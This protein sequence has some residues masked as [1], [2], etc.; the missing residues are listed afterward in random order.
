[1]RR[2]KFLILF[3]LTL[4]FL[5][6][7]AHDTHAVSLTSGVESTTPYFSSRINLRLDLRSILVDDATMIHR[8][9]NSEF[10]GL[11][12]AGFVVK[13]LFNN[14]EEFGKIIEYYYGSETGGKITGFSKESISVIVGVIRETVR[15]DSARV[16][17]NQERWK[18]NVKEIA[19]ALCG[20]NPQ[21]SKTTLIE[22]MQKHL[23]YVSS[24]LDARMKSDWETA[25]QY[26]DRDI[27]VME[28]LADALS[29]SITKQFPE[30]FQN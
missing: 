22:L 21:L 18:A 14:Q 29:E 8:D 20:P 7:S 11:D 3:P 15:G 28:Q 1:M 2:I 24:A 30:K 13:R 23:D 25:F 16:E 17:Q 9:I 27:A 5:Y 6:S 12:D 10:S 19:T 4:L 26:Y